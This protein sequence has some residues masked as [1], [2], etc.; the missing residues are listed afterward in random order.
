MFTTLHTIPWSDLRMIMDLPAIQVPIALRGLISPDQ[1]VRY[2]AYWKLDNYIV[3][4]SSLYEAAWYAIPFLLEIIGD[5]QNRGRREAYDLLYEIGTG[6]S[7][8][9]NTLYLPSGEVVSLHSAC[10]SAVKEAFALYIRLYHDLKIIS[11]H[12][13]C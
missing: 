2:K 13:L 5:S 3:V 11:F 9:E 1:Q 8:E 4:Q 12:C 10:R 7:Q 6:C